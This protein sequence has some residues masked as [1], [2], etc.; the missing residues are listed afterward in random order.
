MKFYIDM[1]NY[2]SKGPY[3]YIVIHSDEPLTK[4]EVWGKTK[5]FNTLYYDEERVLNLIQ[6]KYPNAERI[7]KKMRLRL[8]KLI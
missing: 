1:C 2:A 7:E 3:S 6:E 5:G 8:K 4:F